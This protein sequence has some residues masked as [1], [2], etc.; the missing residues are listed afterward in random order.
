MVAK[1]LT[2]H[3]KAHTCVLD[4]GERRNTGES[5]GPGVH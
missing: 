5:Q 2:L 4:M 1:S 3:R